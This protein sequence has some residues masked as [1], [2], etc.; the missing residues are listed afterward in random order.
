M[1]DGERRAYGSWQKNCRGFDLIYVDAIQTIPAGMPMATQTKRWGNSWS[2]M[3]CSGDLNELHV[4]AEKLGLK[5]EYFQ[6][7]LVP[8]YDLTPSKRSVV[9]RR[10]AIE[11]SLKDWLRKK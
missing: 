9:I 10:G 2:H 1:T 7:K 4:F 8:H 11:M 3:W 5:R 6:N